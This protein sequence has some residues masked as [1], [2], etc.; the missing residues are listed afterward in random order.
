MVQP[1]TPKTDIM[2]SLPSDIDK[3]S[4]AYSV[5]EHLVNHNDETIDVTSIAH[6]LQGQAGISKEQAVHLLTRV[7]KEKKA[8][9]F[10]PDLD[11]SNVS[12]VGTPPSPKGNVTHQTE[13]MCVLKTM[14]FELQ[15]LTDL[16]QTEIADSRHN[17]RMLS[18]LDESI[19][20][21]WEQMCKYGSKVKRIL[22]DLDAINVQLRD[23]TLTDDARSALTQTLND[24]LSELHDARHECDAYNHDHYLRVQK[25]SD[26]YDQFVKYIRELDQA[27]VDDRDSHITELKKRIRILKNDINTI[28]ARI[29]L[30]H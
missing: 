21:A 23:D 15:T 16:L 30:L 29:D 28:N 5:Y 13:L 2:A 10:Y 17:V 22:T 25:Y 26:Y 14:E 9:T 27:D 19:G 3:L 6:H 12:R 8:S 4:L 18:R 7:K 11:I 24:S 1:D 20:D